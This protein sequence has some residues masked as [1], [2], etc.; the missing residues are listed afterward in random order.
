MSNISILADKYAETLNNTYKSI[1]GIY[2]NISEI[3]NDITVIED[4]VMPGLESAMTSALNTRASAYSSKYG[5]TFTANT[6]GG[7]GTTNLTD[8]AIVSGTGD[9]RANYLSYYSS[10][11]EPY[12]LDD[13]HNYSQTITLTNATTVD[14]E[15]ALVKLA[16]AT[17]NYDMM[18]D[19][20]SGDD[21]R[22]YTDSGQE[23]QYWIE[24]WNYGGTSYVWVKIPKAETSTLN[25]RYGNDTMSAG[26]SGANTF[27][28]FWDWTKGE[29]PEGWDEL[30][31]ATTDINY[32]NGYTRILQGGLTYQLD[33][34]LQDG[35]SV[36][37]RWLA[38][39]IATGS[40]YAASVPFIGA[41]PQR[42]PDSATYTSCLWQAI[43][44]SYQNRLYMYGA[45]GD[46]ASWNAYGGSYTGG[47]VADMWYHGE[48]GID[49]NGYGISYGGV[50]PTTSLL[51]AGVDTYYYPVSYITHASYNKQA[52]QNVTNTR[53]KYT[54][55]RK[56]QVY[57]AQPI[58]DT[59]G[60][61]V[62]GN[63]WTTNNITLEF[64]DETTTVTTTAGNNCYIQKSVNLDG[65]EF[66]RLEMQ[67]KQVSGSSFD[68][69][70]QFEANSIWYDGGLSNV[71]PSGGYRRLT[72]DLSDNSNWTSN[73][74]TGIRI[75]FADTDAADNNTFII[76]EMKLT[77]DLNENAT[78]YASAFAAAYRHLN[79]PLGTNGTYGLKALKTAL[80]TGKRIQEQNHTAIGNAYKG[81]RGLS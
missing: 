73:T 22:F 27:V 29:K 57:N 47:W 50:D 55:V 31:Y 60:T 49:S 45:R 1:L 78:F 26:S 59:F 81:Y 58:S 52:D 53:L 36:G 17:F 6:S 33:F 9:S 68:G 8:W 40:V 75:T 63:S 3:E 74:I 71:T 15:Q 12:Y 76:T 38:E 4:E 32:A 54:W 23:C 77:D 11:S 10:N 61:T 67:V 48:I 64:G 79:Q 13:F 39:P 19:P 24:D 25:L 21:L 2:S 14:D 65:V 20:V 34:D 16:N 70:L 18:S 66:S 7:Y 28:H 69:Q 62:S 43:N 51:A 35:Y 30:N 46:T 42:D 80:V 56:F 44:P 37:C 5:V 41:L 72:W